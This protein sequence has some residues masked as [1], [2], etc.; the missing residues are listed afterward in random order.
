MTKIKIWIICCLIPIL[1]DV[2]CWSPPEWSTSGVRCMGPLLLTEINSLI[3]RFM[4]PN[5]GPSGADRTQVSPMLAPW[6]SLLG[7]VL[8]LGG[9]FKKMIIPLDCLLNI[10][11]VFGQNYN[12]VFLGFF[13]IVPFHLVYVVASKIK[14][15]PHLWFYCSHFKWPEIRHADGPDHLDSCSDLVLV[16]VCWF[17]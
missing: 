2:C 10:T 5:W 4:G 12:F 16:I 3:A 8:I 15:I 13:S 17:S 14:L 7:S 1:G 9:C 6:T 11:S